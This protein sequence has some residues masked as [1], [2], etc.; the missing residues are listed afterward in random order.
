MDEAY[1]EAVKN[2]QSSIKAK[3]TG[4]DAFDFST[5]L[6]IPFGKTKEQTI[7]DLVI[8]D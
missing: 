6:A 7:E 1:K 5:V 4:L 3:E 2:C 8:Y